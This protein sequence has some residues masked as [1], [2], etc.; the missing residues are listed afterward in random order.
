MKR[1]VD[2]L[3]PGQ[4]VWVS[5]LSTE[6]A[7]LR[8]ELAADPERARG[9]TFMGVQ[10]PGIDRTNYLSVHPEARQIAAFMSES[11]RE[12]MRQGRADLLALDYQALARYLSN[13]DPVDVAIAQMTPP[14]DRGVCCL[15]LACDFMPLVWARA[16]FRV[17]H[18][19]PL[20]PRTN[21]SFEIHA[22]EID[23]FVEAPAAV[24]QYSE[25]ACGETELRIAANAAQLIRDGDTLQFGIGAVPMGLAEALRSHRKLRLHTG[26]VSRSLQTLWNARALD[27]D[28]RITT[29][30]ILGDAQF[31]AFAAELEPLWLTDVRHTHDPAVMGGIPRFV[32]VNGAVE[33]DLFGQSNSER[34]AGAIQAGSGGLPA[35]AQGA[36]RSPGGRLIVCLP[37]TARK[38]A[39]SRIVPAL[40]DQGLC[41]LPRHLADAVATEYGVAELRGL[42]L[43]RRAAALIA[44]AAPEHRASLAEAWDAIRRRL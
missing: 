33:V 11:V 32:A 2:A 9:V 39:L 43:D 13:G 20:L 6:S 41:T 24:A 21:T 4:R 29:G 16:R 34:A 30:V 37:A 3:Q 26:M 14:D 7:L 15:S 38:G 27:R 36:L 25:A 19:N 22:S 40:G 28:A 17:A 10:F 31:Q 8:D 1:L 42:S 23:D 5:T 35:F 18:I 12:G 44:I